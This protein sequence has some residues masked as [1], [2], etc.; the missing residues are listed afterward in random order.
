M[1]LSIV[2]QR[3]IRGQWIKVWSRMLWS[4]SQ[5]PEEIRLGPIL[6]RHIDH[7]KQGGIIVGVFLVL[8]FF[9]LFCCY[10]CFILGFLFVFFSSVPMSGFCQLTTRDLWFW[11]I[12]Q[13][14]PWFVFREF[15]FEMY[16]D[17]DMLLQV[18][19]YR[20]NCHQKL[21]ALWG[22]LYVIIRFQ[23]HESWCQSS[24]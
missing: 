20:K 24:K 12:N 17:L 8:F 3:S 2:S 21:P 19:L 11:M 23:S 7:Y 1:K 6:K 16:L 9:C 22:R 13:Q 14:W 10:C 15:L 5:T 18:D 4:E